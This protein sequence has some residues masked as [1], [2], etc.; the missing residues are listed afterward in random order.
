M[1]QR[2]FVPA[3][4]SWNMSSWREEYLEALRERDRREKVDYDLIDACKSFV[5]PAFSEIPNWYRTDTQ[6]ADRT[7]ALEAEKAALIPSVSPPIITKDMAAIPSTADGSVQLKSDLSEALR[8]KGQL[9]SRL[10]LAEEEME[11]LRAKSITDSKLIKDLTVERSVLR[12]KVKDRDSELK[13]K[14]KL[15]EVRK[16]SYQAPKLFF[17]F[18]EDSQRLQE[19]QDEMVSLN[20]QLNMAEQRSKKLQKENKDLIDRWMARMGQ[21]ADAMNNASKFSWLTTVYVV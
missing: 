14:T 3:N 20:L 5:N 7:A 1:H 8:A 6:L 4:F 9:Q 11:K 13:G 19:V 10:K 12:T 17:F 16:L 18:P 2:N 15:V 21:E